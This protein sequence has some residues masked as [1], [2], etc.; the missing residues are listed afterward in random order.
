[1]SRDEDKLIRQLSLLSFLL[2][3]TRPF[4]AREI[5]ESVEGYAEMSDDTFTRRFHGDRADL[6]KIGIEIRVLTGSEAADNAEAQLYLLKEE[7]FRLPEVGFTPAELTALSMALAA[8]DGRFAYARPLRLALTAICHGRQDELAGQFDLL[9]VALAPDEDARK[10]GKQLARLEDAVARSR[11]VCFSYP[12]ADPDAAPVERTVD[13]YSLFFIQGHWYVVGRDHL[14]AAVRTFRVT[15]IAGQVRFFTEKNR[16]FYVPADYDPA[17][18]RARPPWLL[19]PVKRFR[20]HTRGRRPGLV[21]RAA[22][23]SRGV[24]PGR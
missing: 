22:L 15:R 18:Y 20:H 7:D 23:S 24:A 11:S 13:P 21:R 8:L 9:P 3:K 19:G 4:T 16:D 5:Q 6:A 10:A 17:A 1:M 12:G 2:S 14:R